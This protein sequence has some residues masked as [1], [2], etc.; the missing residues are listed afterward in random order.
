MARCEFSTQH[1]YGLTARISLNAQGGGFADFFSLL[2]VA[3]SRLLV[4]GDRRFSLVFGR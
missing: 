2:N 1:R 4:S 3:P